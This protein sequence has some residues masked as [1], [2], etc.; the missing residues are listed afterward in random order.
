MKY[1][2]IHD[3]L[4]RWAKQTPDRPAFVLDGNEILTY[5]ELEAWSDGLAEH[6][7][8]LGVKPGDRVAVTGA[9]S[10]GWLPAAFGIL[11]AGAIEVPINDRFVRRELIEVVERITPTVILADEERREVLG[12]VGVPVLDLGDLD[13]ARGGAR[14]GWQRAEVSSDAPALI[15]FT[16]GTTGIPKGVVFGH[17]RQCEKFGEFY[18]ANPG[19]NLDARILMPFSI[20]AAPGSQWGIFL[21]TLAGGTMYF[22]RKFDAQKALEVIERDR[23]TLLLGMP[24]LYEQICRLPGFADADLSAVG[25][26]TVGGAR[27]QPEITRAWRDKGIAIRQLYGMTE[28]GG[29]GIV[30][31]EAD[32]QIEPDSCGRGMPWMRI[33]IVDEKGQDCPPGVQG[34]VLMRGPGMML[35]YW[36]DEEATAKAIDAEG[37]MHTGD[38]AVID[39]AGFFFFVDREKDIIISGGFNIS[40]SEIERIVMR[41]DK[42]LEVSAFPVPDEKFGEV[43]G[44]AFH[45]SAPVDTA[46]LFDHC[47]ENLA[48]F[49]LPRHLFQH[50]GPLPRMVSNKIDRRALVKLYAARVGATA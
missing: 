15:V 39:E 24:V 49:K 32:A 34:Q 35:G 3:G 48:G 7:Q 33:R 43:P 25:F 21:A 19:C 4:R 38:I 20:H 9:N 10:L 16:S 29:T 28:V 23:L 8:S 14:E 44:A 1:G 22:F 31:T 17:G 45:A 41:Y 26:A 40:P 2:L 42:V 18:I 36:Q 11:K 30:A 50:D 13:F 37:W 5:A 46:Q 6:L 47:K 27:M 12:E